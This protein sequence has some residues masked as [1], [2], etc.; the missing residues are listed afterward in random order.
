MSA[1]ILDPSALPG[2][3]RT[4]VFVGGS[5][6]QTQRNLLGRMEQAVRASRFEPI[7]AD[8]FALLRPERDVHDVTLFLL[9][10]CRLA[11]FECSTLSGALMEIE[12]LPDYGT[13][14]ALL[15][16]QSQA[17]TPWPVN[18]DAWYM[19]QMVKSMALEQQERLAV[20]PYFRPAGAERE[21][22][23]FLRAVRRSDYGKLHG[24]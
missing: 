23:A 6:A 11:I 21:I 12:R 8:R 1:A 17:R 20:R 15:L 2:T 9:H 10:A 13:R 22:R 7:V 3:H 5:Y 16:Y 24:L 4:R 14:R 19:S 18:A